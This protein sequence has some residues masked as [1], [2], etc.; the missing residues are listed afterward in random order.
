MKSNKEEEIEMDDYENIIYSHFKSQ[1][2]INGSN[3]CLI[4]TKPSFDLDNT[5]ATCEID[6]QAT[7]GDISSYISF[8]SSNNNEEKEKEDNLIKNKKMTK[9]S[10]EF[11]EKCCL[12]EKS[13]M[14]DCIS[15]QKDIENTKS[16]KELK[17]NLFYLD[18]DINTFMKVPFMRKNWNKLN[19]NCIFDDESIKYDEEKKTIQF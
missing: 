10:I 19:N 5:F 4:K 8:I 14:T 7:K 17:N 15:G 18:K 11:L 12:A 13:I 6:S 16:I 1:F 3:E 9:E 2:N